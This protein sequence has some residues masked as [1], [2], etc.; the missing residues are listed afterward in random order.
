MHACM[1]AYMWQI[2]RRVYPYAHMAAEMAPAD[3]GHR[4]T[5]MHAYAYAYVG[6]V[7]MRVYGRHVAWARL[8]AE[9]FYR[10]PLPDLGYV[11]LPAK[12]TT[13]DIRVVLKKYNILYK[14][15][16]GTPFKVPHVW[17]V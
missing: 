10:R 9:L 15:L 12:K 7:Y 13:R 8:H 6:H 2:R 4:Y 14:K 11:K 5:C 16:V 1:H 17:I 3:A